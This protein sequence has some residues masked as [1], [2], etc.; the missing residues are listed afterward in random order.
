MLLFEKGSI[1][2][3]SAEKKRTAVDKLLEG[4]AKRSRYEEV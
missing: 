1:A 4:H 3:V 2:E